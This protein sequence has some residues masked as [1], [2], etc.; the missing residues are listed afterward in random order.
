MPLRLRLTLWYGSTL[1]LVL[2]VFSVVLYNV[3]ARSLRD[4]VDHAD[5]HVLVDPHL[6]P[7][8]ARGDTAVTVS[9]WVLAVPGSREL[10][11][12]MRA[13]SQ[14]DAYRALLGLGSDL[15]YTPEIERALGIPLGTVKSRL[16]DATRRLEARWEEER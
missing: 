5:A 6:E 12:A 16:H 11:L 3:T 15:A 14:Q 1:A 2:I 7:G 10:S 4:A 13:M 8:G 9:R